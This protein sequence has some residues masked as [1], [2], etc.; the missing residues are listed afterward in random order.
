MPQAMED[1][2][3]VHFGPKPRQAFPLASRDVLLDD[4]RRARMIPIHNSSHVAP[5]LIAYLTQ[6]FNDE[7]H[8]PTPYR[9]LM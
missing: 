1:L 5:S 4:G 9:D 6:E 7:V 3:A 8:R 2:T